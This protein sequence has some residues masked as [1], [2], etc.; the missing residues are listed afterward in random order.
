MYNN[1]NPA[2]M[3]PNALQ[4]LFEIEKRRNEFKS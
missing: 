2:V 3:H 4:F 1:N